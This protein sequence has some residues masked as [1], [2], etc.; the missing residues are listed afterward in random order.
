MP[1]EFIFGQHITGRDDIRKGERESITKLKA[2]CK[3]GDIKAIFIYEVSRLSRSSID[4]RAFVRDFNE[5]KIP[6]NI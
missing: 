6:I 3:K 4:G 5:M 2:A 1:E